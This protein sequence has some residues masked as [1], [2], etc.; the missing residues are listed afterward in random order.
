MD[1]ENEINP[2]NQASEQLV[3]GQDFDLVVLGIPVG[4]LG[5]ICGEIAEKHPPFKEML[6][7]SA[8]V[9]T[10]AFQLWLTQPTPALGWSYSPDSICGCFVEPLDT[11]SDMTHLVGREAWLPGEGVDGLG[12]FCGVLSDVQGETPAQA[13][14]RVKA[15]AKAFL[16][17]DATTLWP[18]AKGTVPGEPFDWSV[19]ADNAQGVGADRLD[20]QYFRANTIGGARYVLTPAG[21]VAH[22]LA[23]G[24]SG[25]QNLVLA[26]DWTSNGIDG[27]CVEAAMTSGM[28]AARALIG[29]ARSFTGESPTWLTE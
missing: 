5:A 26:G 15:A 19:L 4:A 18:G 12:Y 27:G 3:R 13:E 9:A 1:F 24:E 8:T 23:A 16:E 14:E 29:H 20:A 22:R 10:Q 2:D 7:S 11:W 25:V 21:S 17:Q 6:A 28:Q